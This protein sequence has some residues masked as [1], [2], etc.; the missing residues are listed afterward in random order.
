MMMKSGATGLLIAGIFS[1]LA[2]SQAHSATAVFVIPVHDGETIDKYIVEPNNA[3]EN[4]A[5][6]SGGV[7]GA[8]GLAYDPQLGRVLETAEGSGEIRVFSTATQTLDDTITI[9]TASDLSGIVA[10]VGKQK[11]YVADRGS[12]HL[13]VLN[14]NSGTSKYVLQ[15]QTPNTLAGVSGMFGIG[16]DEVRGRL[17]VADGSHTVRCYSTTGWS[18][19]SAYD[20]NATNPAFGVAVDGL[21]GY[22]Y[23][24]DIGSEGDGSGA[25]QLSQYNI[26][27][28]VERLVTVGSPVMGLAVDQATT[29][30]FLTTYTGGS[31][32]DML[33]MYRP[34]DLEQIEPHGGRP[35]TQPAG[36][37]A[38][39]SKRSIIQVTL[40]D[41]SSGCIS[42]GSMIYTVTLNP[43]GVSHTGVVLTLEL[44]EGVAAA[45]PSDPH[46]DVGKRTY[47]WPAFD[48]P[49]SGGLVT[50]TLNVT[51]SNNAEPGGQLWARAAAETATSLTTAW[52]ETSVC[53]DS[54]TIIYVQGD[55]T[56]NGN[57]TSWGNA[58]NN[59]QSALRRAGYGCT[60]K[61]VW[62]AQ[63]IY[64]PGSSPA[65]SFVVPA[66]VNVC[67]GFMGYEPATFNLSQRNLEFVKTIL[68]GTIS[69]TE[70][71]YNDKV[72][73]MG[74]HSSLNGFVVAGGYRGISGQTV[75]FSVESCEV[76]NN[77][78]NGI[79]AKNGNLTIKWCT[80]AENGENGVYAYADA[81]Y[82]PT[83]T[84]ANSCIRRNDKNGVYAK[85]GTSIVKNSV[86]GGNGFVN[87]FLGG[88]EFCGIRMDAP[89][90]RPLIRNCTVVDNAYYGIYRYENWPPN[91]TTAPEVRN[92]ILWGNRQSG[93]TYGRQYEGGM[94]VW[95]SCVMNWTDSNSCTNLNPQFAYN[96]PNTPLGWH[97]LPNSP[98]I[99][100]GDPSLS[101]TGESD[102]DNQNRVYYGT[103]DIGADEETCEDI[104]N[105]LDWDH[106]GLVNLKE[107]AIFANAWQSHSP[108]Q[109]GVDPNLCVRW[110][111][112]VN[113]NPDYVIDFKD[114]RFFC[115]GYQGYAGYP[116]MA[117]WH[118]PIPPIPA[119]PVTVTFSSMDPNTPYDPNA[120][121]DPNTPEDPNG[122]SMMSGGGGMNQMALRT[123]S[124]ETTAAEAQQL[125]ETID[126]L[127]EAAADDPDAA[128][129]IYEFIGTLEQ[130]LSD[131]Y[132][133]LA[134]YNF[135]Q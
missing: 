77:A 55:K 127:Y 73:T 15:S 33:L 61:T 110:N 85:R 28:H 54:S 45:N 131:I 134:G 16:G 80:V 78:L 100:K 119:P 52:K 117:C 6:Y 39:N 41:N 7:G 75:N 3:L 96:D 40:T 35:I 29:M 132:G 21:G 87:A 42:P 104:Y 32:D 98:C 89:A 130:E 64:S 48:M 62:V 107:F 44:P 37:A 91:M 72:V 69:E 5:A 114:L 12:N 82:F 36:I 26:N 19:L 31:V 38:G 25:C 67:G 49:S 70:H 122:Y 2:G 125:Q 81:A 47:T 50:N 56:T 24:G 79:D 128:N 66:D 46:Y 11:V 17:Y 135:T 102:I 30:I 112:T 111:E 105:P 90:T 59:L 84:I 14:W 133:T 116:W 13:F 129:S 1:L 57:G 68:D 83:T 94:G 10:D 120:P 63:G 71:T 123:S 34:S 22:V 20:V 115:Q 23:T 60:A 106:D 97:I 8:V 121:I 18:H 88:E 74:N 4:V 113:L 43:S 86:I 53:C 92:C 27:T 101:Y 118:P 51:V 103:V 124:L 65:N 108:Q 95:Y 93:S 126:F 99:N 109:S 58:Y 76:A 9:A